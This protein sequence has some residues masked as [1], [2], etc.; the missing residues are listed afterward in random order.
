M[1]LLPRPLKPPGEKKI[2]ITLRLPKY[3]VEQLREIDGYNN[4]V[5]SLLK[6]Y[7]KNRKK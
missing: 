7:F 1:R 6:D 2:N 3:L 5:E 4:I